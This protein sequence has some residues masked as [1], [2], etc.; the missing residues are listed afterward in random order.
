LQASGRVA[1]AVSLLLR[2]EGFCPGGGGDGQPSSG[3]LHLHQFE[4]AILKRTGNHKSRLALLSLV[5]LQPA[6]F[7]AQPSDLLGVSL[8]VVAV[9]F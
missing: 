8:P 6:P 1:A 9:T 4:A 2:F 3:G 5:R 7:P